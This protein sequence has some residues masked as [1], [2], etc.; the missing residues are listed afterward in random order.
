MRL[1]DSQLTAHVAH[2]L[3]VPFE[4]PN[5][6]M[7]RPISLAKGDRFH[8]IVE[9]KRGG[10]FCYEQNLLFAAAFR[11]LGF[12]LELVQAQVRAHDGSFGPKF[13]HMAATVRLN[14][15]Q[16]LVDVG[17]GECFREPLRWMDAGTPRQTVHATAS[18]R[19][20]TRSS[21][22]TAQIGMTERRA[23]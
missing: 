17:F 23:S 16:H 1:E 14:D 22:S 8:K 13:D 15:R 11:A 3:R 18:S 4:N 7:D 10:G 21:W 12:E 2:L 19:K 20:P 9:E 5:I 6:H